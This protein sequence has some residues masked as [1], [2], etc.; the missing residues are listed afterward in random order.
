M[1]R[2][3]FKEDGIDA[4]LKKLQAYDEGLEPVT[5]YEY[6]CCAE[7]DE[8]MNEKEFI[9]KKHTYAI[10]GASGNKEKYGNVI[11]HDLKDAGYTV[12]PINP[13]EKEIDGIK[14]YASVKEAPHIDVAVMVV[15]PA[16]GL[17]VLQECKEKKI[18]KIW[19]QPGS[20]DENTSAY[21]EDKGLHYIQGLCIM[22]EKQ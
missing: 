11:L 12:I 4:A 21:C 2:L 15:P 13:K 20:Y 5:A 6:S 1:T 16:V 19:F 22:V 17:K 9:N 8:H 14:T 3:Q 7:G 10:I 18:Q